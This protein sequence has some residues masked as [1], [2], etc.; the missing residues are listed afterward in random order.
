MKTGK[1]FILLVLVIIAVEL[2]LSEAMI[3]TAPCAR[4]TGTGVNTGPLNEKKP[5]DLEP[6]FLYAHAKLA[7]ALG[8]DDYS[9]QLF[10]RVRQT[11]SGP[12]DATYY[13]ADV[14]WSQGDWLTAR[15]AL[16]ELACSSDVTIDVERAEVLLF[17]G[18]LYMHEHRFSHALLYTAEAA[19][20]KPESSFY[21][22][23]YA[24]A[25]YGSGEKW[26]DAETAFLKSI[27]LNSDWRD[28]SMWSA[29]Y[30]LA[31]VAYKARGDRVLSAKYLKKVLEIKPD[32]AAVKKWL[33]FMESGED[34]SDWEPF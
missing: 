10:N 12:P 22:F 32:N 11:G 15:Q 7:Y 31:V 29:W 28:G 5:V 6:L 8:W 34:P 13:F 30:N 1:Y 3:L 20:L 17:L 21:Q 26:R 24:Q 19:R 14:L 23:Q 18:R 33:Q 2:G 27:E 25:C 16:E 4:A 9:A